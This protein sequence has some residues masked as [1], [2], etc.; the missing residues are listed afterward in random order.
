MTREELHNECIAA[1]ARIKEISREDLMPYKNDLIEIYKEY[2]T[3][4]ELRYKEEV[5]DDR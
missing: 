5:K 3:A 2:A 1:I 4:Y